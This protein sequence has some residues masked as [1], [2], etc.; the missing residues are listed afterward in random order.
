MH[1][2]YGFLVFVVCLCSCAHVSE[3]S[4]LLAQLG[5]S[6]EGDLE[7]GTVVR[8]VEIK[9]GDLEFSTEMAKLEVATARLRMEKTVITHFP[10]GTFKESYGGTLTNYCYATACGEKFCCARL[11]FATVSPD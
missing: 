1:A 7:D 2:K 8:C 5:V 6:E 4:S 11:L 10:D 9:G 3:H